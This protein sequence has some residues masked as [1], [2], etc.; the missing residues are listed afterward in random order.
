MDRQRSH[1]DRLSAGERT[2]TGASGGPP[3]LRRLLTLTLAL[4]LVLPAA[5]GSATPRDDRPG[6][7]N[8]DREVTVM[9][10]NL[11]LGATLSPL[12]DIA[13]Q[14][15]PLQS[16]ELQGAIV[17]AVRAV[18]GQVQDTD[19]PRRAEALADEIVAADALLVGLQEVTTY[20]KGPLPAGPADEVILDFLDV[21]LDALAA[22]GA[23]YRVLVS[24]D[25]FDGALP[26]VPADPEEEAF[27]LRLT[28]RDVIIARADVPTSQ[29]K[30]LGTASGN[31]AAFVPLRLGE[32]LLPV[33]R[34]WVSAD[35]KHR[36]QTFRFVNTHPEA[37][38]ELV[39]FLQV[40]ELVAGPLATSLPVVLVGD[41]NATPDS[42]A[43]G[44]VFGAGF[45]DAADAPGGD[46]GD[47]C[48]FDADVRG[49]TLDQRID[50]VLYRGRFEVTG[51]ERVGLEPDEPDGLYPSDHAGVVADLVLSPGLSAP[52]LVRSGRG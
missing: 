48:C 42:D 49:G 50:Y 20:R 12:L 40:R 28:D 29:L 16:P 39:N 18:W 38:S 35:V 14:D 7:S 31:F 8:R 21:L 26:Y 15:P 52:G 10:R 24:V 45:L 1:P 22:R 32:V 43:M 19:F 2:R 5:A 51:H 46:L 23:P 37:F 6:A 33:T 30:V 25:N 44:L 34:G 9:S 11:Y 4:L 27:L 13:A 17:G 36:G 3:R 41:L 47:T